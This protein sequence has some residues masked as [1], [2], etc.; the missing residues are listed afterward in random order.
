MEPDCVVVKLKVKPLIDW[1]QE[2]EEEED[3]S[4]D[5]DDEDEE[6]EK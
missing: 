4:S 1:L 3:S 2:A 6:E 5:D